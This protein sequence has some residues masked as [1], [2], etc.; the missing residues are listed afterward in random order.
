M[1]SISLLQRL[2]EVSNG[3]APISSLASETAVLDSVLFNLQLVL[4]SAEGCCET[5][6]DYGLSDYSTLG[7][8]HWESATQLARNVEKQIRLFEPRLRRISV[9]PVDEPSRPLEFVFHVEA[10][11]A[12]E[13]RLVR[14]TFDSVLGND[15]HMRFSG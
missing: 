9:R 4:N 13:E 5:R 11:L 15:G 1:A 3:S 10:E 7:Q 14:V 12:F 2:E 8:S 6:T